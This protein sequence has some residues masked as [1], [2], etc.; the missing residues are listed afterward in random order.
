M[1]QRIDSP[2]LLTGFEEN[3]NPVEIAA[4]ERLYGVS[5][6][7]WC[8]SGKGLPNIYEAVAETLTMKGSNGIDLN[9]LPSILESSRVSHDQLDHIWNVFSKEVPGQLNQLELR[10]LLGL[11]ALAQVIIIMITTT[12]IIIIMIYNNNNNNDDD[13]GADN[14]DDYN[15]DRFPKKVP[16]PLSVLKV[17]DALYK[18]QARRSH[19]T[20]HALDHFLTSIASNFSRFLNDFATKA[21]TTTTSKTNTTF[22]CIVYIGKVERMGLCTI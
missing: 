22:C 8:V 19:E 9:R 16:F 13:D 1:W 17:K 7:D 18:K 10:L 15:D 4:R 5:L 6:P 14:D 12:T 21:T 2:Q 20:R 3:I 11:V